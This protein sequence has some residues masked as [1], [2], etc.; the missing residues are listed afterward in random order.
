MQRERAPGLGGLHA[1][2]VEPDEAQRRQ[3]PHDDTRP[4]TRLA[5]R[6]IA[7]IA[8]RMGQDL[9]GPAIADLESRI[10]RNVDLLDEELNHGVAASPGRVCGD[11]AR[12]RAG[13]RRHLLGEVGHRLLAELEGTL[14][15]CD[16]LAR[17]PLP[18]Q[19][20][21]LEPLVTVGP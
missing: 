8:E 1:G 14:V 10:Q 7:L 12:R 15:R 3:I 13:V 17:L 2:D 16:S 4:S 21:R 20:A 9:A 19:F 6:L 18:L 11:V 5:V